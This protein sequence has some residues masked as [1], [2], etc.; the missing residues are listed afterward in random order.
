MPD[1]SGYNRV[2]SDGTEYHCRATATQV[3]VAGCIHEHFGPR[4]LCDYHAAELRRGEQNCGNCLGTHHCVLIALNG[5][6]D[7]A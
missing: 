3:V 7:H 2:I 4:D 6:G 5:S 1:C